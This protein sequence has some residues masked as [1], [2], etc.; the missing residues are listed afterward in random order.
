MLI[1]GFKYHFV[2]LNPPS[3][4]RELKTQDMTSGTPAESEPGR[5]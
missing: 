4:L 5:F 3:P 2:G 1:C